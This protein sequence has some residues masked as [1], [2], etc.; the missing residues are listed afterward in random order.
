MKMTFF[1]RFLVS[2]FLYFCACDSNE[3]ETVHTVA[4]NRNTVIVIWLFLILSTIIM[5]S[6]LVIW[7]FLILSTIILHSQLGVMWEDFQTVY[8]SWAFRHVFHRIMGGIPINIVFQKPFHCIMLMREILISNSVQAIG[9][10]YNAYER[11][12]DQ[13]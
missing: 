11:D 4:Q 12:T 6:Q 7:L 1:A 3:F 13:Q 9:P 5:H 8:N 2:F 10:F